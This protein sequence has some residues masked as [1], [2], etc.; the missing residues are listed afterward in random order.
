MVKYLCILCL[1]LIGCSTVRPSKQVTTNQNA[2]DREDKKVSK[3]FNEL[4]D[5]TANQKSQTAVLAAGTQRS[6]NQISN[7]PVEV[8]TAQQLNERII[9]IVGTPNLDELQK[10]NKIVDLLNSEIAEERK[11]GEKLLLQRDSQIVDLQNE[12]N[13]IEKRHAVQIRSLTD[14]AKRS[15][16]TADEN[17]AAFDSMSGFFGLNAVVWGLKKFIFSTFTFLIIFA[18]LFILLRLL[19]TVNPIAATIFSIF[20]LIGSGI[21]A[22]LKGLTPKAFEIAKFTSTAITNSYKETLVKIVD[23]IQE[24]K[25]KEQDNPSK[26]YQLDEVLNKLSQNMNDDNKHIVDDILVEQKWRTR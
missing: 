17:Q 9:N 21:L 10:I 11:R 4:V 12:K 16:K 19:S 24:L 13:D 14:V 8:I 15:A 2:I 3:I 5:N 26:S 18:I 7:P 6:L 23:T 1:L 20:D 25:L 22:I